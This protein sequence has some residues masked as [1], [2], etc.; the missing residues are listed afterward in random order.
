LRQGPSTLIEVTSGTWAVDREGPGSHPDERAATT[1][2]RSA[3]VGYATGTGGGVK[4]RSRLALATTESE[5]AAMATAAMIGE[6][7]HPVKG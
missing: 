6:R 7:S 1:L 4:C 3:E 2:G 5:L